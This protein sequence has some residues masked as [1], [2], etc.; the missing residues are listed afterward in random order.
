LRT[1][2][3]RQ[4]PVGFRFGPLVPLE[5]SVRWPFS[6]LRSSPCS[7]V[8][9][10]Y[11][12]LRLKVLNPGASCPEGL[13]DPAPLIT[14]SHPP[15]RPVVTPR[16]PECLYLFSNP[17]WEDVQLFWLRV[18]ESLPVVRADGPSGGPRFF[19]TPTPEETPPLGSGPGPHR[20]V[21]I[22]GHF[23]V[24]SRRTGRPVDQVVS[25]PQGRSTF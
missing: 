14:F 21:L 19:R 15:A 13:K 17:L 4:P 16:N 8:N 20:T 2:D 11:L 12:L 7:P 24:P 25:P 10:P 3:V 9:R 23:G 1:H 5:V 6:G 22:L 18:L